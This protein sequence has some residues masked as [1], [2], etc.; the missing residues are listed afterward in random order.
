MNQRKY[1]IGDVA[2]LM[3]M[4]RD[5]IRHYEKRGLITA[6]KAENGYR[7]Y[8][9]TDLSRLL[10]I[11]YQRKM[12]I[13]LND[14]A[15][16]WNAQD[17]SDS[18]EQLNRIISQRLA[19]E[20]AAIEE[21]KRTIARLKL[22]KNDCENMQKYA[23]QI[24]LCSIPDS[25]LIETD[26]AFQDGLEQWFQSA[27][28]YNGLDTMYL[29][30]EFQLQTTSPEMPL[31]DSLHIAAG[32]NALS[33]SQPAAQ[34]DTLCLDYQRSSLLLHKDMAEYT[35]YSVPT[36]I[37]CTDPSRQYL[38]VFYTSQDRIPPVHVVRNMIA[39]A[40]KN[41]L[42]HGS[43]LFSTFLMQ[44]IRGQKQCYYMQLYLAVSDS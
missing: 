42:H 12:D 17:S 37:P 5:T 27:K 33:A 41:G 8:T 13:G 21:H 35:D 32:K 19:E 26:L 30:D 14:L 1:L 16:L 40:Q 28:E 10:G 24:F 3:G 2:S 11:L 22:T 18:N 25:Y 20:D 4:S 23:D 34:K 6:Q 38:S 36:D 44:G 29:F 15:A 7:Y 43:Q 9:E 39:Y 31:A